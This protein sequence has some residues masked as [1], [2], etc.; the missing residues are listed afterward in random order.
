M[1]FHSDYPVSY[2]ENENY[3]S[4]CK[5]MI[6]QIL[7]IPE[8]TDKNKFMSWPRVQA[9][10]KSNVLIDSDFKVHKNVTDFLKF[11]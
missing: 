4:I 11:V 10:T 8:Y 1:K 3:K 7:N 9:L 2:A 6:L 5:D